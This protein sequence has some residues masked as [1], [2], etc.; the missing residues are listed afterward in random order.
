[1]VHRPVNTLRCSGRENVIHRLGCQP[2]SPHSILPSSSSFLSLSLSAS[3]PL[4]PT[5][6][7]SPNM[8]ATHNTGVV[9]QDTL[10][11]IKI[12]VNEQLKKLKLPLRDLGASVLPDKVCWCSPSPLRPTQPWETSA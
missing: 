6:T 7:N 1:M 8:D 12:S 11:I 3:S 4:L 10:I 9:S 2:S 5:S